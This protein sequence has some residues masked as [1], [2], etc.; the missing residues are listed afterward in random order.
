[1]ETKKKKNSVKGAIGLNEVT[2]LDS[3]WDKNDV[4]NCTGVEEEVDSK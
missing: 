4:D 1:M 3:Y 2:N